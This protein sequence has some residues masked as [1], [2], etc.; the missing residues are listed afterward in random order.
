[1]L[2]AKDRQAI[3]QIVAEEI[4]KALTVKVRFERRRDPA[5]GQPLATPEV[6]V[7]D[8]YLPAHWVEFLPFYEGA[9]RG[10]QET[11]DHVKNNLADQAGKV[12]QMGQIMLG[13]ENAIMTIARLAEG[14]RKL[15]PAGR[16]KEL[17]E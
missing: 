13:A 14:V 4:R 15:E 9:M 8:V 3:A 16:L 11:A 7:K 10:V 17:T 12:D 5:T 2:S 6:E 1:M